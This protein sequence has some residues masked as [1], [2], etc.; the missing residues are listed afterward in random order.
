MKLYSYLVTHNEAERY[1]GQTIRH[2]MDYVDGLLV[3]D[4]RS[5]D[6]AAFGF[7]KG[8]FGGEYATRPETV[9]SFLENESQ[10][11]E[12][13]WQ[14]MEETF[15]PREGDWIITLDADEELFPTYRHH[16]ES[17]I[18]SI[19][20]AVGI[21]IPVKEIWQRD[22]TGLYARVDGF[23]EDISALRLVEYKPGGTFTDKKMGGGS[24]PSYATENVTFRPELE[25]RHYGYTEQADRDARYKRYM[26]HPGHNQTHIASIITPPTLQKLMLDI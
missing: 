4:D 23:W 7:F 24:V 14:Q 22:D 2:L 6:T 26:T 3:Y 16:I 25:I 19:S 5:N 13:A 21:R 1:L 15:H 10:F 8:L 9:P 17:V 11:R 12:A 18:D 20:H